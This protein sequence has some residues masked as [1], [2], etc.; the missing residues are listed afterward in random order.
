MS[1]GLHGWGK[2]TSVKALFFDIVD[3]VSCH[4]VEA[5]AVCMLSSVN[6]TQKSYELVK[7]LQRAQNFNV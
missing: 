3:A 4:M 2:M 6:T 7:L 5:N 1:A